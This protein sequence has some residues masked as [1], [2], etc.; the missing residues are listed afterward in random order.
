[1]HTSDT[2]TKVNLDMWQCKGPNFMYLC[3]ENYPVLGGNQPNPV[4]IPSPSKFVTG[5]ASD[6]KVGFRGCVRDNFQL[7]WQPGWDGTIDTVA[8]PVHQ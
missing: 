5:R 8:V 1:M 6:V 4:S 3:Y 2:K 7:A